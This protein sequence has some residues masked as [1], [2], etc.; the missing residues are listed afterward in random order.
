[1]R[2]FSGHSRSSSNGRLEPR[3]E[4]RVQ[5]SEIT[6]ATAQVAVEHK[7]AKRQVSV[8]IS[9]VGWNSIDLLNHG[10]F[11]GARGLQGVACEGSKDEDAAASLLDY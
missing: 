9:S 8:L 1:V 11:V 6:T 3:S 2:V 4:G 7:E 10:G 5:P